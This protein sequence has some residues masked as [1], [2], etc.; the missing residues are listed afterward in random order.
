MNGIK[1]MKITIRQA[2]IPKARART[3][4]RGEKTITY[5]PQTTEK[6]EI[7]HQFQKIMRQ[8]LFSDDRS[9][10]QEAHNL[11]QARAFRLDVRFYMPI[12]VS[13]SE[14]IRN[15]KLWGLEP[16]N[17]RPDC[18]NM[19]KFYEDAAN[20]VLYPDD[21]MIVRGTYSKDWSNN[22][23]TEIEIMAIQPMKLDE[24]V[25]G[26]LKTIGPEKLKELVADAV[27]LARIR[28]TEME[29]DSG[30]DR[31]LWL[32]ATANMLSDFALKYSDLLRKIRKYDGLTSEENYEAIIPLITK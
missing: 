20:E 30:M 11:A 14:A 15:A 8:S 28:T 27:L 31:Q 1:Y 32:V 5:D 16:C 9:I 2:P 10:S 6:N 17:K 7:R 19:V 3:V 23:R 18:T 24:K 22:P 25:Q 29:K 26:I 12:S 4:I 21:C 13:D